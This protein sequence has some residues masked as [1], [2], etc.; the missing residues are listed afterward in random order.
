[1]QKWEYKRLK[2]EYSILIIGTTKEPGEPLLV[3]S[4][5]G[6]IFHRAKMTDLYE[7][8]NQIGRDGWELVNT[9]FWADGYNE[10]YYFKRPIE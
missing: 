1:M 3:I 8:L 2:V 7:H 6:I 5:N 9:H 4:N 10:I